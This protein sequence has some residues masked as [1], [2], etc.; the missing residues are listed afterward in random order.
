VALFG[1]SP[2]KRLER[3]E[4]ALA[5]GEV[6]EAFRDFT[7][8]MSRLDRLSDGDASRA[9][10][11]HRRAREK[12]IAARMAEA[13]RMLAAGETDAA[14]DN[15]QTA[16]D[17]AGDDLDTTE[18]LHFQHRLS[19]PPRPVARTSHWEEETV[20]DLP[21]ARPPA[22]AEHPLEAPSSELDPEWIEAHLGSLGEATAT[23]YRSLG[24]DFLAAYLALAEGDGERAVAHFE[25]LPPE[26][27]RDPAVMV[28]SAHALLLTGR[29]QEAIDRLDQLEGRVA[30]EER[31]K[32]TDSFS[33]RIRFLRIEAYRAMGPSHASRAVAAAREFVAQLAEPSPAADALLAWA[34]LEAGDAEEAYTVARPWLRAGTQIEE[35]LVPAAHAAGVLGRP[36]EARELLENLLKTRFHRSLQREEPVEFP[37]EA[38]RKLLALYLED[39]EAGQAP[40]PA[41]IRTLVLHLLDHDPERAEAYHELLVKN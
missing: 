21:T 6:F 34:L 22:P 13:E 1:P 11:G 39:K 18:I 7:E 10:A 4:A 41:A 32:S 30:P 5:R 16:L 14:E 35:I 28:E 20:R 24:P 37:I 25:A 8:L 2:T 3:A 33:S 23:H 31:G 9:R 29:P 27:A 26:L 36:D 17:L 19:T 12:L 15:C 38:G 40:D